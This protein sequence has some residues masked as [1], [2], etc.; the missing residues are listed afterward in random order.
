MK[1]HNQEIK[2]SGHILPREKY[3]AHPIEIR[4]RAGTDPNRVIEGT[5]SS[6]NAAPTF[7]KIFTRV[8]FID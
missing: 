3:L 7:H 8:R 1:N 6:G 2:Y 4:F 5:I